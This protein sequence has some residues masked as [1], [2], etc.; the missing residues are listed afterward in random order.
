MSMSQVEPPFRRHRPTILLV[1]AEP[2]LRQTVAKFLE[3]S[4]FLVI[5]CPDA[6]GAAAALS[7]RQPAP[8]MLVLSARVLDWATVE[9]AHRLRALA[10]PMLGIADQL[11]WISDT[12]LELP[13]DLRF[14][15][16]P[17]DLPDVLLAVRSWFPALSSPE[18]ASR[19]A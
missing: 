8:S 17:F 10:V 14:L 6:A 19:L 15:A 5:A 1:E 9:L 18:Q 13:N 12:P 4:A 3:R 2:M 16:P 7:Q 11:G